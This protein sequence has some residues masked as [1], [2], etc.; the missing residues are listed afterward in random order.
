MIEPMSHLHHPQCWPVHLVRH[1]ESK[2]NRDGITQGQTHHPE[3]TAQGRSQAAAAADLLAVALRA[4]DQGE[5]APLRL[6][7]SDLVR[8]RQTAE[9]IGERLGL[10][11]E[12]DTRLREQHLGSLQGLPHAE[13]WAIAEQHDWS[14]PSLP[15]AG[16]ESPRDVTRRVHAALGEHAGLGEVVL[17]THGDAVRSV[18]EAVGTDQEGTKGEAAWLPFANGE[19]LHLDGSGV[20]RGAGLGRKRARMRPDLRWPPNAAG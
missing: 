15:V 2:W 19:V 1:G 4:A 6:V 5:A 18:I 20:V 7:S 13:S 16:G 17:V 11:V 3:L 14:D 9:I 10:E 12:L 8:A